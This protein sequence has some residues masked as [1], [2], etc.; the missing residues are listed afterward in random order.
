MVKKIFLRPSG[1]NFYTGLRPVHRA[2]TD[3]ERERAACKKREIYKIQF[4]ILNVM[5]RAISIT[6]L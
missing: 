2:A 1:R 6:I 3:E 4:P 5:G